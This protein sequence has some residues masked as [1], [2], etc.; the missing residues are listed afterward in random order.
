MNAQY[1]LNAA[2]V[3]I[4]MDKKDKAKDILISLKSDYSKSYVIKDVDRYMALV[5]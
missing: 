5:D 2:I 1:L 4:E 3:Y